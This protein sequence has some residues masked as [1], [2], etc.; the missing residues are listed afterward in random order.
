MLFKAVSAVHATDPLAPELKEKLQRFCEDAVS[1][2]IDLVFMYK[3]SAEWASQFYC[4][5]I[6]EN[7]PEYGTNQLY[8]DKYFKM[9]TY[10]HMKA[11]KNVLESL[12]RLVGLD[13]DEVKKAIIEFGR[14]DLCQHLKNILYDDNVTVMKTCYRLM[15][16]IQEENGDELVFST[17]M[18]AKMY[19]FILESN[20]QVRALAARY[21]RLTCDDKAL[22]TTLLEM[23]IKYEVSPAPSC[24]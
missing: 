6:E 14:S 9:L 16:A 22:L 2:S 18:N 8:L 5:I 20:Q 4:A 7:A 19:R 10:K 13:N 12:D 17:N 11:N 1:D 21:L 23:F 3:S 24:L 15:I